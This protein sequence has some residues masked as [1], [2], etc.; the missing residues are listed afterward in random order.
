RLQFCDYHN[1]VTILKKSEQ[2]ADFHPI[3]DFIKAPPLRIETTEE[4]TQ[5]LT[6]VDGALRTVI[7]SSLR[8]NLKLQDEDGIRTPTEPHHTPSPEA[9]PSSHTHISSPLLP[10]VTPISTAL[11]P[12]VTPSETNPLRQ[13][14][15]RARIA[16]DTEDIRLD[17][18]EVA[19][20]K[21][22]DDTEELATVLITMDAESVLSSGG[23]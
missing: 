18:G 17:E 14:T 5:I 21:V 22:S 19:A 11:I 4:G 2:N 23:V 13:Y 10:T 12:T 1:M 15:R 9:L 3:V 8:R 7:E 6:T 20:D 16:H